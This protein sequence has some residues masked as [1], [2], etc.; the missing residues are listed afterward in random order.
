M[1]DVTFV[2]TEQALAQAL[3]VKTALALSKLRFFDGSL[4]VDVNT[5]VADMIAAETALIGYPAGGY[6]I[7]AM[8]G[9]GKLDAGG[10]Q[11]TTPLTEVAY[12]SGAAAVIGGGWIETA[13]GKP[14]VTFI[15]DPKRTL[16]GIGDMFEFARQLVYGRNL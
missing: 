13:A 12:A 8:L 6:T 1:A 7:T 4:T 14:I 16:A 9:P 15:F 2:T 5:P 11:I 3:I 10:A